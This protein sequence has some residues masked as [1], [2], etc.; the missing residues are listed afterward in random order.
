LDGEKIR[1]EGIMD[2]GPIVLSHTKNPAQ[3]EA[4]MFL[5]KILKRKI[6]CLT[7]V[8]IFLGAYIIMTRYLRVPKND[9]S[10]ALRRT[11]SLDLPIFYEDIPRHIAIESLE[12]ASTYKISSWDAYIANLAKVNNIK[13]VYTIDIKDFERIP[14]LEPVSPV[15]IEKLVEYTQWIQKKGDNDSCI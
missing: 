2:V 8:S 12:D 11:L 13:I 1:F 6:L 7:P 4:L 3:E 5:E 10:K 14:W 9:A 15:S